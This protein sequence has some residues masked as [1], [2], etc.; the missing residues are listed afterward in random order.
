MN[1]FIVNGIFIRLFTVDER[2]VVCLTSSLLCKYV[3]NANIGMVIKYEDT[4]TSISGPMQHRSEAQ[5]V[6][7]VISRYHDRRISCID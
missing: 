3:V 2:L 6:W 1:R 5:K 7:E 4:C